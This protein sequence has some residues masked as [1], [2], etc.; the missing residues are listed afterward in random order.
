MEVV[1]G[2]TCSLPSITSCHFLRK[3]D[4]NQ[5]ASYSQLLLELLIPSLRPML[6]EAVSSILTDSDTSSSSSNH[7]FVWRPASYNTLL[8]L[9]CCV[10]ARLQAVTHSTPLLQKNNFS[11]FFSICGVEFKVVLPRT[12]FNNNNNNKKSSIN[13][14]T[15]LFV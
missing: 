8:K 12:G 6:P 7:Q 9:Q 13:R 14:V 5:H 3:P 15:S 2:S 10:S 4:E 11:F 1:E